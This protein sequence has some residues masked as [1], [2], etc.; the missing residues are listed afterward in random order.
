MRIFRGPAPTKLYLPT[1]SDAA[2][3]NKKENSDL[4][5]AEILRYAAEG[6]MRSDDIS[7]KIGT[8]LGGLDFPAHFCR[9]FR[10]ASKEGSNFTWFTVSLPIGIV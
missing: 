3:S 9:I 2:L 1:F 5:Y 7:A 8:R 10:T 4:E 6:V